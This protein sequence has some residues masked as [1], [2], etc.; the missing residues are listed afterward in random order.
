VRGPVRLSGDGASGVEMGVLLEGESPYQY[1]RVSEWEVPGAGP[2]EPPGVQRR[3]SLDEGV[4]EYQSLRDYRNEP[5]TGGA[6]YDYLALLPSVVA[7]SLERPLSVVIL[8]GG[9][10]TLARS[11]RELQGQRV[12]RILDVELDPDVAALAARFGW[13]PE[14]P[15]RQ[16]VGDGRVVLRSS[17]GPFDLVI[18]DAYARQIDIPAHLAS[19]EF[20]ELVRERLSARGLVAL[21]VSTPSLDAPLFRAL[22]RTLGEVYPTVAAMVLP[23]DWWNVILL[24]SPADTPIPLPQPTTELLEPTRRKWLRG[25]MPLARLP[26]RG[27]LLLTDDRAPVD[28]LGRRR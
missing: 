23:G 22:W 10:G 19:R 11:L 2:Q 1:L 17:P 14:P 24:A 20:F 8:G 7:G 3:L 18:L 28:Q 15:D 4:L 6:Y 27:G 13:L 12:E 26:T 9:A 21:N 16:I 25:W 5:L